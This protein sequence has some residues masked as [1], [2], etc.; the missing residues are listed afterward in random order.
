[1]QHSFAKIWLTPESHKVQ[2]F[3]DCGGCLILSEVRQAKE[4]SHCWKLQI[5][6]SLILHILYECD[7]V[8]KECISCLNHLLSHVRPPPP[9]LQIIV[10]CTY[11]F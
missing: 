7:L 5:C 1:M 3:T 10:L 2:I 9:P 8:G 11:K 6:C 4:C